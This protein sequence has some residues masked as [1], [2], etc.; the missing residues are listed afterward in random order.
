MCIGDYRRLKSSF[1][2]NF[3]FILGNSFSP[4][5]LAAP[6]PPQ[7][8]LR[9]PGGQTGNRYT[10]ARNPPRETA[11]G[12]NRTP[13][14]NFQQQFRPGGLARFPLPPAPRGNLHPASRI[15]PG[16]TC[17][18]LEKRRRHRSAAQYCTRVVIS[19]LVSREAADERMV[20][21]KKLRSRVRDT[22]RRRETSSSSP[23]ARKRPGIDYVA[24]TSR[25]DRELR[26]K[27]RRVT[28]ERNCGHERM[29]TRK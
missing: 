1:S 12:Q 10:S 14:G 26:Q 4:P 8:Y 19:P 7:R 21:E 11:L 20:E 22:R 9:S 17:H 29:E 2:R 27:L 3:S 16:R 24:I 15:P 18:V 5:P 6:P 25:Q 28:C 23:S 13:R